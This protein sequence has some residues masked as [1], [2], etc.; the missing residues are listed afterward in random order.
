MAEIQDDRVKKYTHFSKI[1]ILRQKLD[2]LIIEMYNCFLNGNRELGKM[3]F[4]IIN[5]QDAINLIL[6]NC[7]DLNF[8]IDHYKDKHIFGKWIIDDKFYSNIEKMISFFDKILL[9]NGAI[10]LAALASSNDKK[11]SKAITDTANKYGFKVELSV[12][13]NVHKLRKI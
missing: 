9:S 12:N 8:T 1:N 3:K 7:Y 13:N 5:C 11:Y 2:V 6:I 10:M 4:N